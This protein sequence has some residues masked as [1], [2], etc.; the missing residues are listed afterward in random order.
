MSKNKIVYNKPEFH[1]QSP[2]NANIKSIVENKEKMLF[3]K[4]PRTWSQP[5]WDHVQ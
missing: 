1:Q 3:T 5:F 2:F 4:E